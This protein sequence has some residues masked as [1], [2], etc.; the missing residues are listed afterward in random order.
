MYSLTPML[1]LKN[2]TS[3]LLL[4]LC[5]QFEDL[6][7]FPFFQYAL[8]K[9]YHESPRLICVLYTAPTCGP[10]RTLKPILSNVSRLT[11]FLSHGDYTWLEY[12]RIIKIRY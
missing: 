5:Y 11:S 3:V 10:C 7:V 6:N 12:Y 1:T 9:L 4:W 2:K 8:R